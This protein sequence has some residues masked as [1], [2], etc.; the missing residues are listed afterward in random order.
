MG[1]GAWI[2]G[3]KLYWGGDVGSW[4]MVAGMDRVVGRLVDA[5]RWVDRWDRWMSGWVGLPRWCC[6]G[7]GIAR[8]LSGVFHICFWVFFLAG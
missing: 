3:W 5:W 6:F 4:G 8:R 7:L 1:A 2:G